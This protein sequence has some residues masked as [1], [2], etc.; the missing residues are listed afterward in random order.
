MPRVRQK[1]HDPL[2]HERW[3]VSYADFITLLF[4]F[5][6]VMYSISS[7][8]QGKY[9]VL[10]DS[11]GTAFGG[12][13]T[14]Q[15][16]VYELPKLLEE[17]TSNHQP[18]MIP[19]LKHQNQTGRAGEP[20]PV[21]DFTSEL[22]NQAEAEIDEIGDQVE[23]E[24]S[25]LIEDDVINVKRNK[26]WLEVEV[27]SS[28]LFP[29]AESDLLPDALPVLDDLAKVFAD[30]P[31]RINVEGF[32]DNRPISTAQFPSNWELSAARAAAVVR[33]F[34]QNGVASERMASIGY[35]EHSPIAENNS[36]EGRARN[37]RVVLV[38]MAALEGRQ[39][40]R[41]YEFELLKGN[42]PAPEQ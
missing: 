20:D 4:A 5:F 37:R 18:F 32:T 3:L 1:L 35:G 33:L 40:E 2:N 26:F 7:V 36:P 42:A 28:L 29:S 6:V 16:R 27:K 21:D 39:N 38:V 17:S 22:L 24:M 34:E 11:I 9:R 31:N 25:E 30:L 14:S 8:N 10:S 12:P 23:E 13:A 15:A 19:L 41:I